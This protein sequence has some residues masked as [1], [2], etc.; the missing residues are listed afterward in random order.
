MSEYNKVVWSEGLFLRPQHFQQQ[1]R[2]VERYVETRTQALRSHGWG[3]SE[4]EIE[5]DLLKIGKIGLRR[6][7]GV[8]PDGTPFRLPDDEP[9]P[10]P[11]DIDVNVRDRR[12][13]LAIPLRRAGSV[14][15]DRGDGDSKV[16]RHALREHELRDSTAS[17]ST[18]AVI[19]VAPLAVRLMLDDES[20]EGYARIPL[21]HVLERRQDKQVLLDDHFMPTV[22]DVRAAPAL[23]TFL[24]E[25]RGL[26]HQRGEELGG[27]VSASGR[28]G[29]AEIA[30]FLM[31]QAI[32]RYEPV[33]EHF[34]SGSS[35][36][37]EDLYRLAV[38]MAGELA[39]FT[40]PTKRPPDLPGYRHEKLRESFEPPINSLRG[41]L[42][43]FL[44]HRAI[45][46]PLEQKQFGFSVATVSDRSLYS[47]AVFVLA[48]R[49]DL[50]SEELRRRFPSQFKI[51]P[52]PKIVDLVRGALPGIPI[53][54]LPVAP[55]QIPFHAGFVYF[56]LD[57]TSE[58]WRQ[59]A[60]AGGIGMHV[61][62]EFP[63]LKMELWAIR[64]SQ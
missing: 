62:G 63:G 57:Q 1:D 39:T 11:I 33:V 59:L 9:V 2:F 18:P 20:G 28:G 24:V 64:S 10:E 54:P 42:S 61:G 38:A 49:A 47:T 6:A 26:M 35:V 50:P 34:V 16:A 4:L 41:S 37:P 19:E 44:P 32:N 3:F 48:V 22:L 43:A 31:L 25:L 36:H 14:E 29:A 12:V 52:G 51:G 53:Q 27:R 60:D 55:R 30:D 45:A 21:A 58:L 5:R 46:I 13:H 17:T 15:I 7:V 40:A 23:A 56:E 8:F